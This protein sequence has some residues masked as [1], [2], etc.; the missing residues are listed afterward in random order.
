VYASG[1]QQTSI[2]KAKAEKTYF[3]LQCCVA[4]WMHVLECQWDLTGYS[5]EAMNQEPIYL[6]SV[7]WRNSTPLEE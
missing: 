4:G 7:Y 2:A 1:S 3:L 6:E 5:R